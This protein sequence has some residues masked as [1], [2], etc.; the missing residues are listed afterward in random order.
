MLQ[1]VVMCAQEKIKS[2]A[3]K[4]EKMRVTGAG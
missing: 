2:K 3:S 4:E 1:E